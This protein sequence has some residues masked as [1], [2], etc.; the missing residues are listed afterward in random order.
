M[1]TA[2]FGVVPGGFS[3]AA[4]H[5]GILARLRRSGSSAMVP[6]WTPARRPRSSSH[7]RDEHGNSATGQ[8]LRSRAGDVNARRG[9]GVRFG[10]VGGGLGWSLPIRGRL[11]I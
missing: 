5:V 9:F 1:A 8:G 3:T 4:A 11:R 10:G 6:V 2:I 7:A